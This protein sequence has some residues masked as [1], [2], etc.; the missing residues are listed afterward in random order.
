M[1]L[2]GYKLLG[3]ILNATFLTAKLTYTGLGLKPGLR[4]N[5]LAHNSLNPI[6]Y[7]FIQIIYK[8]AI[9]TSQ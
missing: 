3:K 8:N 4:D 2:G 6:Q 5:S 7:S 1:I 9:R